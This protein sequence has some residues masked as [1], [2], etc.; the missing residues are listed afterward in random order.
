M[1]NKLT[2]EILLGKGFNEYKP[3]QFDSSSCDEC[4]QKC[5]KD[6]TGKKYF[7]DVKHY[8]MTHPTTKE[9]IGGYEIETQVY[10]KGSHDAINIKFLNDSIEDAENFINNL[11]EQN[12][13]EN[14]EDY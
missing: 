1:N 3:S 4:W 9:F 6:E 13:I 12:M 8:S 2:K 10:L 14:Y 11:F 5:Y 7:L